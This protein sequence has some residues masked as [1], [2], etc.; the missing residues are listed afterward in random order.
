MRK[1][2]VGLGNPLRSDDGVGL[3]L[4][5]FM[6]GT[7]AP[8]GWRLEALGNDI[9]GLAPLLFVHDTV[10]LADAVTGGVRPGDMVFLP[11]TEAGCDAPFSLH[12]LEAAA[13][14]ALARQTGARAGI[15][16]A[17]I[18]PFSLELNDSLTPEMQALL[19]LLSRRLAGFLAKLDHMNPL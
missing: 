10:V 5:D 8:P 9:W 6:R 15:W 12:Q 1:A 3:V 18:A 16:L 2:V 11:F 19:P 4:V 13:E 14:I 17:G 7:G